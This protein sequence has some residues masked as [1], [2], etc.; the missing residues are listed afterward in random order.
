MDYNP[1]FNAGP[2]SYNYLSFDT[3]AALYNAGESNE[4]NGAVPVSRPPDPLESARNQGSSSLSDSAQTSMLI[5]SSSNKQ[6][7]ESAFDTNAF[8]SNTFDYTFD[9]SLSNSNDAAMSGALPES[10]SASP[11]GGSQ[12]FSMLPNGSV[13]SGIA[14]DADSELPPQEGRRGSSEEKENLTPAQSRRK[15]QNRAA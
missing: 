7:M 2:Q 3:D 5:F 4:G 14:L 8:M 9:A 1:Y 15:A 13:D 10:N 11:P 12:Q 6:S